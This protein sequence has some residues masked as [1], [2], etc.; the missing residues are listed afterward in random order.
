MRPKTWMAVRVAVLAAG[1]LFAWSI[2]ATDLYEFTL[3]GGD[4]TQFRGTALPNP[5]LTACFYGAIGLTVA[6]RWA[7][8][9][10][11]HGGDARGERQ[12]AWLLLAGTAF[13][14]GSLSYEC[15]WSFTPRQPGG[16]SVCTGGAILDPLQT[17]CFVGSL[18]YFAGFILTAVAVRAARRRAA[19]QAP[20]LPAHDRVA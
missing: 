20:P 14:L 11:Q 5:L 15:Y 18:F 13:A 1:A 8:R 17:P 16:P 10:E 3:T 9:L 6:L 12:L 7:I 2:V 4:L 19:E